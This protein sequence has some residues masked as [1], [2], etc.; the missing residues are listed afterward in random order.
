MKRFFNDTYRQLRSHKIVRK[1]RECIS[2]LFIAMFLASSLLWYI[3]KLGYTYTTE[4]RVKA[5]LENQELEINC[6][7]EGVGTNLLGYKIKGGG[8][9]KIPIHELQYRALED[10]LAI[11]RTSLL[12]AISVRFSDIKIISIERA[13][14]LKI[15][16]PKDI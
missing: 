13:Q 16:K 14:G 8:R 15:A 10:S 3:S 1:I 5:Q 6:V 2:P 11:N 9:V 12:N 4:L 7:V